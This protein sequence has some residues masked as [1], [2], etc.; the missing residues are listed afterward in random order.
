MDT[1]QS[2]QELSGKKGIRIAAIAALSLLAL[3]LAAQTI[4]VVQGFGHPA[5]APL[6]TIT[7]SGSGRATAIPDTARITF[8]VAETASSVAAAQKAATTRTDAALSAMKKS[9]V[10]DKDVKTMSYNVT[11][12]YAQGLCPMGVYCPQSSTITGYQVSQT[13]QVTVR[14]TGKAGDV[15]QALGTLGVQNIS[16]PD[17]V[18]DD[19][20]TVKSQAREEA[21][22]KARAQA[23]VLAKQLGVHLGTVIAFSE[24]G[25]TPMPMYGLQAKMDSMA[26]QAAVAPSIP[27]GENEYTSDVSITYE[28]K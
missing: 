5:N 28:I 16:G 22:A 14:D 7:V 8:S 17:L 23:Q 12:Q 1:N 4:S 21:I 26:G 2:L 9:G 6:N 13:I 11:P 3:F 19:S 10:A 18:V 25:N 20:D 24:N 15:L 27:A